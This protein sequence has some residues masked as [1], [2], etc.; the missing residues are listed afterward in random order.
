MLAG[1]VTWQTDFAGDEDRADTNLLTAQPIGIFQMGG[2][3]YVRSSGVWTFDFEGDRHLVPFGLG[4]GKVFRV[5]GT[6]VNAFLEPQFSAYAEGEGQP[7]TQLFTGL[8]LQWFKDK[9]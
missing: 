2:G 1:L 6:V 3:Y 7:R 8:N 9:K 4:V 5:G